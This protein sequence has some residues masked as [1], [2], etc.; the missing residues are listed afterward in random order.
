MPGATTLVQVQVQAQA[1]AQVHQPGRRTCR[2]QHVRKIV[3]ASCLVNKLTRSAA[4]G[5]E[6]GTLVAV[7]RI[8]VGR[9]L[10]A[11][12]ADIAARSAAAV[13]LY[14]KS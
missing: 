5:A 1:Q 8:V 9:L 7:G 3:S 11:D 10:A 2:K 12:I 13:A 6:P 4:A 14:T